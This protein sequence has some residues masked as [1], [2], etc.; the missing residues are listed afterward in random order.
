MLGRWSRE[1]GT[2]VQHRPDP[3]TLIDQVYGGGTVGAV[4]PQ[5]AHAVVTVVVLMTTTL[6]APRFRAATSVETH[7]YDRPTST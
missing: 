1:H 5:A 6:R 2:Q 4:V 7:C 3:S